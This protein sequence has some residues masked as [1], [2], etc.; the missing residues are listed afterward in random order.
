M[1]KTLW[2][3]ILLLVP[4]V[5][6]AQSYYFDTE[7]IEANE[8]KM[9]MPT[10]IFIDEIINDEGVKIYRYQR[11]AVITIKDEYTNNDTKLSDLVDLANTTVFKKKIETVYDPILHQKNGDYQVKYNFYI[12]GQ[13]AYSVDHLVHVFI[14]SNEPVQDEK[15]EPITNP[16]EEEVEPI[17]DPIEKTYLEPAKDDEVIEQVVEEEI[18]VLDE[19]DVITNVTPVIDQIEEVTKNISTKKKTTSKAKNVSSPKVMQYEEIPLAEDILPVEVLKNEVKEKKTK[20]FND[21]Y[22]IC[23]GGIVVVVFLLIKKFK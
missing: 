11:R 7:I 5:V 21:A 19:T 17:T 23:I 4:N 18:P 16:I 14:E 22:L 15:N 3:V 13:V 10:L 12:N 6:Y 1:K 2:L 20:K 8:R 9:E